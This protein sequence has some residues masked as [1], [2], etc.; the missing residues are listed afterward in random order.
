MLIRKAQKKNNI[1]CFNTKF[2]LIK[3][4]KSTLNQEINKSELYKLSIYL[5]KPKTHS[6]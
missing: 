2:F 6:L 1:T 5:E 3:K 4:S